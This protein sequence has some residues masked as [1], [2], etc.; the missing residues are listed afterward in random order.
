MA[1][2]RVSIESDVEYLFIIVAASTG[3]VYEHQCAGYANLQRTQ[4]G[5]LVQVGGIG[6]A[7]LVSDWFWKRFEGTCMNEGAWSDLLI[8]EL[9]EI[10]SGIP[11]CYR[12]AS[13]REEQEFLRLDRDRI[14]ECVEAWIPVLSPYGPAILVL[15]N[16]D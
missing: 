11:C 8:G 10:V 9:E 14:A 13:G 15:N 1:I 12:T 5:F 6:S 3:V 16:S 4:E 7:D 2:V